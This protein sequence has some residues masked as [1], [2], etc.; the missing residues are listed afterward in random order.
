MLRPFVL[1]SSSPN[2]DFNPVLSFFHHIYSL[3]HPVL[4]HPEQGVQIKQCYQVDI[5]ARCH[6]LDNSVSYLFWKSAL[7]ESSV[8]LVFPEHN[9]DMFHGPAMC[10][11]AEHSLVGSGSHS[12]N[13]R[14]CLPNSEPQSNSKYRKWSLASG[15]IRCAI[16]LFSVTNHF[17]NRHYILYKVPTS[18]SNYSLKTPSSLFT[19]R[20][21]NYILSFAAWIETL[22]FYHTENTH[23]LVKVSF[24]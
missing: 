11:R 2:Q 5:V 18:C 4:P 16:C 15:L 17:T 13:G 20:K 1:T 12:G 9:T 7:A 21:Q 10:H 14:F 24:I 8:N 6:E 19:S 22:K 3:H 23:P